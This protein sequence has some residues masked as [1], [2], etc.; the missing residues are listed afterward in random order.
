[1]SMHPAAFEPAIVVSELPQ[2]CVL[3]CATTGIGINSLNMYMSYQEKKKTFVSETRG[4]MWT[5]PAE[6]GERMQKVNS[7]TNVL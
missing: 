4:V 2:T 1:M 6:G 5:K 7:L 3:D